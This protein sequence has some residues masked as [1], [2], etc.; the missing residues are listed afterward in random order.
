MAH[1]TISALHV[2]DFALLCKRRAGVVCQH[3]ASARHRVSAMLMVVTALFVVV[4]AL[5]LL[6]IILKR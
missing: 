2:T 4:T 3:P 5:E 1:A 6:E